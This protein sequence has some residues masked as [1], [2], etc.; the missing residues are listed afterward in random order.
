MKSITRTAECRRILSTVLPVLA[1]WLLA[2]LPATA[3]F[4][5]LVLNE[6]MAVNERTAA[7]EYGDYDDWI[8]I[9]NTGTEAIDLTGL[10]L[11]DD[12]GE[13]SKYVF[14]SMTLAAGEYL[15]V[16]TDD[17]PEQGNLHAAFK[18]TSGGESVY[19]LDG[20]DVLD[21]TTFPALE[22]DRS[23]GRWPDGT[24]DWKILGAATP[25]SPN[26]DE[27][28]PV[29]A[30]FLNEVMADNYSTLE[31][32][33]EPGE[34]PDWIEL[35]NGE[36]TTVELG[37][38]YLTDDLNDP[39]KFQIAEGISI[40]AGGFLVFIA[41]SEPEQGQFHTNFKLS[42][43]G[44]SLFLFD[45]GTLV[46]ETTFGILG[47][48]VSW[49]RYPDGSENWKHLGTPTPG[50]ENE[51]PQAPAVKL[52]INEF[53]ADNTTT[54]ENPDAA[55][56][57]SD[58]I[59]IYNAE[60][61]P[62]DLGGMYLSDEAA[63]LTKF[64][65]PAGVTVPAGG[66]L[67]FW[68]DDQ[69]DRGPLHTNFKLAKS[70][71]VLMLVQSDGMTQI[72]YIDYGEQQTDVSM[73]RYPDGTDNWGFHS[74]PTPGSAN[75]PESATGMILF[76]D[77]RSLSAGDRFKLYF[78]LWPDSSTYLTDAYL[79]LDVYGLYFSWPAWQPLDAGLGSQSYTVYPGNAVHEAVFDF[80]WPAVE[81][82][83]DGLYFYAVAMRKGT[84]EMIGDLQVIRFSYN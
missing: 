68:A 29:V 72:D 67:V 27:Q 66:H 46:D 34:F 14:P 75:L 76:L 21:S 15:L 42:S 45:A 56:E 18:L 39:V 32:P 20:S 55:G 61:E 17:E 43:S 6:L 7:D 71:E 16:W 58:W 33:Q 81:G 8:E 2:A 38:M 13:P 65:I 11:T 82:S 4:D 74:H 64:P 73:G 9:A 3:A 36:D 44:E 24:G 49:G 41:D 54:I 12:L 28:P 47:S 40:P 22:A 10:G 50:R 52:F 19:L 79:L 53:M 48:D 84:Y 5:D 78:T 83:A 35:Y 25:G 1:G 77:D 80:S 51:D 63:D 37:G 23:W 31:D 69:P 70:D 62:V 60:T 59:E 30:V 57:Y 26:R